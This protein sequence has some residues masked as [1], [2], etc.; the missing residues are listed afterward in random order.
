MWLFGDTFF[1]EPASDG[2][3]WR[4]SS[5]STI[6]PDRSFPG[7]LDDVAHGLGADGKPMQLLPHT[8]EECQFNLSHRGDECEAR[9]NCGARL[10]PWPMVPIASADGSRAIVF[11]NNMATGSGDFDFGS[12]SGSVAIW[13]DPTGP[14]RR[15]E[16]P[17]F[18][19]EEPDWGTAGVR[20][21]SDVFLYAFE[22]VPETIDGRC[23][24][25]R[26]PFDEATERSSYRFFAGE[27]SWSNEWKDAV[28]VLNCAPLFSVHYVHYLDAFVAFYMRPLADQMLMRMAPAPEG[29]WSEPR[30]LGRTVPAAGDAWN[31]ALIAHPEFA[32]EGGRIQYLSYTRPTGFL[33]QEIRILRIV[34]R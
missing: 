23:R 19:D 22:T 2:F 7:N 13:S 15:I 24:L 20:I 4:S 28:P 21:G 31:Y 10:T 32:E 30:Q 12:L 6:P 11:Y 1:P 29:P 9:Q 17:L 34:F 27:S 26:V 5:W 25:A 33:S 18:S 14:A 3:Q 16:P 8:N